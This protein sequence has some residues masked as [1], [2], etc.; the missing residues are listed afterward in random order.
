MREEYKFLDLNG[1]R[2][3]AAFHHPSQTATK[4][5]VMCC[6]LGEEK[7]WSHR[8]FHSLARELA[9]SGIAAVR[10]DYRGEGDSDRDFEDT[11][12]ETR[13]IDACLAVD[14]IRASEPYLTDLTLL[15]LRFGTC[16]AARTAALRNDVTRLI[17]WEPVLDGTAYMQSVLRI[18]LMYQ[19]ALHRRVVQDRDALAARLHAGESANIEGYELTRPL[20]DQVVAFTLKDALRGFQGDT[21]L[22]QIT[23]GDHPVKEE[24]ASS[25]TA[26]PS[27]RIAV[28]QEEPFWRETRSFCQR[29]ARLTG[30]TIGAIR[31][32]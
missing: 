8:V 23:Q 3:F 14:S 21:L 1:E 2:V 28:V 12:L 18:N 6:P 4:A 27:A 19:M 17:L 25:A 31:N 30:V 29:A 9:S 5:V 20:Y 13:T 26:I 11:D 15:G 24:L 32:E 16:V 7:L 22:V 10:F